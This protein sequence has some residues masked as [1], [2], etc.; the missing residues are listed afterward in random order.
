MYNLSHLTSE[1]NQTKLTQLMCQHLLHTP[2]MLT[3]QRNN[4]S[5]QCLSLIKELTLILRKS[6]ATLA[7]IIRDQCQVR[8][9]KTLKASM[10]LIGLLS[11]AFQTMTESLHQCRKKVKK[12]LHQRM[13]KVK[14]LAYLHSKKAALS[15]PRSP[16]STQVQTY[17][18]VVKQASPQDQINKGKRVP[19]AR[20]ISTR[21]ELRQS[22]AI[23][24]TLWRSCL[25]RKQH[26]QG[27]QISI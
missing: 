8:A 19:D 2:R 22:D 18:H 11:Q 23:H 13:A 20:D 25:F 24:V 27:K 9:P 7:S 17:P 14:A 16:Q 3:F 12:W 15:L 1:V 6:L 10:G 21:K 5:T 4:P 26:R